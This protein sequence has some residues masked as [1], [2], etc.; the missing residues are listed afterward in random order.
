VPT[1]LYTEGAQFLAERG[2]AYWLLD[3]IALAQRFQSEVAAEAFQLWTL[4]VRDD[5]SAALTCQNGNGHEV[6]AKEIPLTDFPL[7]KIS[8]YYC[9]STILLPGEY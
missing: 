7:E 2:G 3:E 1:I 5:R 6:F 9:N 8:L 4:T